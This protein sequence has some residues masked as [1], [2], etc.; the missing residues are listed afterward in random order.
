M[1][2]RIED[3]R[4]GFS[5]IPGITR[6]VEGFQAAVWAKDAD[7][8]SLL[9][10][11]KGTNE[12]LQQIDY[13][14][15][16]FCGEYASL[17]FPGL[18]TFP[19]DYNFILDGRVEQDPYA[20]AIHGRE[21]FGETGGGVRCGYQ[22]SE[23][24][25]P[26][27]E[28]RPPE[29][30]VIYKL[31][32]RGFTRQRT[33][34]AKKKGTF[35][36]VREKIPYLCSLGVTAVELMPA[37]DFLEKGEKGQGKYDPPGQ[38]NQRV[39]YWGYTGG[40][41]F[42]PKASY[43]ATK[44]PRREFSDM[45][46][47]L[48]DAGLECY[49]DFFFGSDVDMLLIRRALYHWKREYGVDG[50]CVLGEN[51][52]YEDLV[53]DPMFTRTRLILPWA[54]ERFFAGRKPETKN[55][56][57]TDIGFQCCVRRFL[58]GDE[59]MVQSFVEVN[60]RNPDSFGVVN[61]VAN[62]DGFTLADTV[63]YDYRHNEDN[64]EGN[65]DGSA[66]NYS[67]NCGEEG[68]SRKKSVLELRG[69]LMRNAMLMLLLSQGTPMLYAGDEQGNSQQGNNNAYCQDNPVGWVD[70]SKKK[71]DQDF[72]QFVRET[73]AFR[74]AHPVFHMHPRP[75]N[76]D[77][78][79]LGAPDLSYH[80]SRAWYVETDPSSRGVGMLYNGAYVPEETESFLYVV[81]NMYWQEAFY[82]LPRLPKGLKWCT[83]ADTADAE[84]YR[85][86]GEEPETDDQKMVRLEARSVKILC[87]RPDVDG[88]DVSEKIEESKA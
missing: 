48:H 39:N 57:V 32:V 71:R 56:L 13:P 60:R 25:R 27:R 2:Q 38:E 23:P 62:N 21:I 54:E 20:V 16:S 30:T 63:C 1:A 66:Q 44:N 34:G 50:F 22:R 4:P 9:L 41:Y 45:V 40:Y 58:K 14:P 5:G 15:E 68:P 82:A 49:M 37:Y 8:V 10:Y 31:H 12:I 53:R 80:G 77:Y 29:D 43:C 67:W 26:E 88:V 65:R 84:V 72:L 33:S 17:V 83:M 81:Y 7:K 76:M 69:R 86:Q 42:V 36:G 59:D 24:Y 19:W 85:A 74:K 11:K 78:K 75:K 6:T 52:S 64:G 35:Q 70:W 18:K 61:Y 87:A 46:N 73:I 55:V 79:S 3:S 47:A 51:I 28:L